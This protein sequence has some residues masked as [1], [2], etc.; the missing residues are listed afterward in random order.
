ML[1]LRYLKGLMLVA[2]LAVTTGGCGGCFGYNTMGIHLFSMK[3]E[4]KGPNNVALVGAV[5]HCSCG[6]TVT[7]DTSGIATLHFS[8]MGPYYIS[9]E[10]QDR[11]ISSYN[12]SM[13]SDGG[14]TLTTN[15]MPAPANAGES[16]PSGGG[17]NSGLAMMAT[18]L[19]PILFQY[20][21][22]A[23]GYSLELVPYQAGQYTNWTMSGENGHD[24]ETHKAFLTQLADGKQWWQMNYI[25]NKKDTMVIE[26]LFSEKQ[27]SVRRMR[28]KWGN[29]APKEV[30]VTEGWYTSPM[31]LT[32][33]SIDGAV[34]KKGVSVT[35]A[36]GTFS[37]DQLEFGV[38]AGMTLRLWRAAGVPGGVVKYEMATDKGKT[39]YSGELNSFGSGA[40]TSLGSY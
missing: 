19:Y 12:V 1:R 18:R 40:M 7:V 2:L 3:V 36:A 5:V 4:V 9:V 37:C 6:E 38:N 27:Q 39:L 17:D 24:F 32:P 15:Y 13:P 35:V 11:V 21:F 22:S 20:M 28:Q 33:E 29:D 10:Y 30:P 16:A 8:D 31:Q 25:S 26:V 23:Y 14:K 34:V